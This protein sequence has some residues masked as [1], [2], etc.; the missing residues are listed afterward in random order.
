MLNA[1]L[2]ARPLLNVDGMFGP[3]T[4]ERTLQFQRASGLGQDGIVGPRTWAALDAAMPPPL[5]PIS[6]SCGNGDARNHDIGRARFAGPVRMS[7]GSGAN[8][9]GIP[10][11]TALVGSSWEARARKW[12]G[13]S[14]DYSRIYMSPVVGLG[15]R[16]FT[17]ALVSPMGIAIQ[18][19]NIGSNP[20]GSDVLHELAHAWQ[21]QHHPDPMQYMRACVACQQ[22]AVELNL[23]AAVF[24]PSV[25]RTEDFPVHR[26]FSA[27]GFLPGSSFGTYGGEQIAQQMQVGVPNIALTLEAAPPMIPVSHNLAS[28]KLVTAQ[29]MRVPGV[30]ESSI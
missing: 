6:I 24:S 13:N 12:Y 9:S 23:K 25:A 18:I 1:V 7:V 5:T 10:G 3:R 8:D 4:N 17:V 19:L 27:Y 22:R 14:L 16:P 30:R 20:S 11:L 26:P 21:S 2:A 15:G 28:L 29:D